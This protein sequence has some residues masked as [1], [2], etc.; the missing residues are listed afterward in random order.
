MGAPQS[1]RDNSSDSGSIVH[2]LWLLLPKSIRE[3]CEEVVANRLLGSVGRMILWLV[4]VPLALPWLAAVWLIFLRGDYVPV[5]GR[6]LARAGDSYVHTIQRGFG[7][8]EVATDTANAQ[9]ERLDYLQTFEFSLQPGKRKTLSV[10]LRPRQRASL[11]FKDV[12]YVG[13]SRCRL[14]EGESPTA[15]LT[16]TLVR[17]EADIGD[18]THFVQGRWNGTTRQHPLD[19]NWWNQHLAE[20]RQ[21]EP[22]EPQPLALSLV[23]Q[24]SKEIEKTCGT[25][26][27]V[28]WVEVYKEM[29]P[30]ETR[31]A[32]RGTR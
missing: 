13:E 14:N 8:D 1:S 5:A 19:R 27:A 23:F 30:E 22:S 20:F 2:V 9:N 25:V 18:K 29:F 11:W 16:A 15:V 32:H 10:S 3:F 6:S 12:S 21:A 26:K 17:E 24:R 7:V 4:V 31:V 28:G